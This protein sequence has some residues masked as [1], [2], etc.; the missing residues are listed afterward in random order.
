M[1]YRISMDTTVFLESIV[2]F[3]SNLYSGVAMEI[4]YNDLSPWILLCFAKYFAFL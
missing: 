4:S 1:I 2:H 3:Y